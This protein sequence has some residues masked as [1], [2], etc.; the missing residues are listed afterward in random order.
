MKPMKKIVI[1][2]GT[3]TLFQNTSK[4]S[5]DPIAILVQ[6][7]SDLK[8]RGI[9]IILVSSGAVT[10]GKYSSLMPSLQGET[11]KQVYSSV[12]QIQI[13]HMWEQ[14]FALNDV[15]VGQ[16][17][18]T[19]KNFSKS[20]KMYLRLIVMQLLENSIIPIINENDAIVTKNNRIGNNDIL[21]SLL[22]N[23]IEADTL[24]LLTDQEGL[25]TVDPRLNPDA[26]LISSVTDVNKKIFSYASSSKIIHGT[27]GMK[28]KIKAAQLAARSGAQT[29]IACGA[30]PNVLT[31][32]FSR[33]RI[34]T[35][36]VGKEVFQ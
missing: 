34:G 18:L 26:R 4:L 5:R 7:I 16:L 25:Y 3:N 24:I 19:K 1:K 33:K 12:G 27:G 13:M 21:A 8:K 22:V 17:L 31:D 11:A 35:L 28:T 10:A 29:I 15:Q 32:I 2:I 9:Q 20:N 23:L 6:Q 30:R 14:L 36:F